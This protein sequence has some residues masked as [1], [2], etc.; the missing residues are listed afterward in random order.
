MGANSS[1]NGDENT[2]DKRSIDLNNSPR[3]SMTPSTPGDRISVK[4]NTNITWI[5]LY[6]EQIIVVDRHVNFVSG[7]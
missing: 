4:V 7:T 5:F 2:S 3:R 6:I 1:P